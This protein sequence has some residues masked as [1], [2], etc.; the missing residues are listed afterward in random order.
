MARKKLGNQNPTQSVILKY[1]R[2]RSK[3]HEAVDIYQRTGLVAV[4][5]DEIIGAIWERLLYADKRGYGYYK[6]SFS[7][8]MISIDF[9]HRQKGI[10]NQLM[11]GFFDR[12]SEIGR[13]GVSLS[14]NYGNN[15]IHLYEK[16]GFEVVK[17][18]DDDILMIKILKSK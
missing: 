13:E 11:I 10:G 18:R 4:E 6:S 1:V 12:L 2:K 14:V 17:C 9:N 15:A 8:L 5:D 3:A 7:E 16:F